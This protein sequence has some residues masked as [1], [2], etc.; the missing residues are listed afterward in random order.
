MQ[1][2][3]FGLS[4][5]VV[6]GNS[7]RKELVAIGAYF[8]ESF[9]TREENRILQKLF[10][11]VK[12]EENRQVFPDTLIYTC[13]YS[14]FSLSRSRRDPLKNFEISVLRLIRF[15]ELRKIQIKPP[16]FTNKYVV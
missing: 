5:V 4:Y 7:W 10:P 15:A 13:I 6:K 8:C 2:R 3:F 16:N 1:I 14:Q 11:F 12:V 9:A